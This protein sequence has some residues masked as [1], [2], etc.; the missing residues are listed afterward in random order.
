MRTMKTLIAILFIT[1]P[2]LSYAEGTAPRFEY[3]G[4]IDRMDAGSDVVII[5]D[6]PFRFSPGIVVRDRRQNAVSTE[7][8]HSGMKVGVKTYIREGQSDPIHYVHEIQILPDNTN[9]DAIM[10]D[11]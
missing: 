7:K 1:L 11:D 9:L 10:D 2:M 6:M 4:T 8:L 5:G 3:A